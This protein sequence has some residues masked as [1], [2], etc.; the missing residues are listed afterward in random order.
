MRR[1]R[2]ALGGRGRQLL[3]N[4]LRQLLA[5]LLMLVGREARVLLVLVLE[6]RER[7]AEVVVRLLHQLDDLALLDPG[8]TA[9]SQSTFCGRSIG[10]PF[11]SVRSF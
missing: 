8:A 6:V 10:T 5:V 2:R 3:K 4:L 7:L 1:M 11:R 9:C